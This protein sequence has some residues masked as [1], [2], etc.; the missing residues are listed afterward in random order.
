[1]QPKTVNESDEKDLAQ[2]MERAGAE[3]AEVS[4]DEDEEDE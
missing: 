2:M 3:N 1:M 4:G